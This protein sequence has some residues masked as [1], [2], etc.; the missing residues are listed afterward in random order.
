MAALKETPLDKAASAI[1]S[2]TPFKMTEA[3]SQP[4]QEP[5]AAATMASL[6][7]PE[8]VGVTLLENIVKQSSCKSAMALDLR[9]V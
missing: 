8:A 6:R 7:F 5:E 2:A 9:D 1:G 3:E 4:L